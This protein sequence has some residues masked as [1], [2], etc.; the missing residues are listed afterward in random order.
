MGPATH[1][2]PCC[3]I[4]PYEVLEQAYGTHD[5]R[6]T[7]IAYVEWMTGKGHK[8]IFCGDKT[9]VS[10]EKSHTAMWKVYITEGMCLSWCTNYY[11]AKI[12]L[13]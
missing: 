6:K 7:T 1:G 13:S 11:S 2:A 12:F 3:K 10:T 4:L 5:K 8:G 9:T